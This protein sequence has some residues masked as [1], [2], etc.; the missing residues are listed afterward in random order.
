MML[1]AVGMYNALKK[2]NVLAN[3]SRL[4]TALKWVN[5]HTGYYQASVI[6]NESAL[7]RSN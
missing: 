2:C 7:K 3:E 5:P 4:D 6:S 1:C